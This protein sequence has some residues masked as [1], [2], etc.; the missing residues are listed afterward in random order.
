[1]D[2]SAKEGRPG[3]CGL[4]TDFFFHQLE[5]QYADHKGCTPVAQDWSC[6]GSVLCLIVSA[7]SSSQTRL[8]VLP[9]AGFVS[10]ARRTSSSGVLVSPSVTQVPSSLEYLEMPEKS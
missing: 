4:C 8:V 6:F 7:C 10:V 5:E 3:R 1:M 9:P 2:G